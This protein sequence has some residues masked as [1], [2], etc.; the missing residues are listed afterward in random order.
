MCQPGCGRP[1]AVCRE[2]ATTHGPAI[3]CHRRRHEPAPFCD[4]RATNGARPLSR[5]RGARYSVVRLYKA[6]IRYDLSTQE[7]FDPNFLDEW[8]QIDVE[9]SRQDHCGR[10]PHVR[11]ACAP[12][13]RPDGP[14]A[15]PRIAARPPRPRSRAPAHNGPHIAGPV[16]AVRPPRT[17]DHPSPETRAGPGPCWMSDDERNGCSDENRSAFDRSRTPPTG[18][19]A[20][21]FVPDHFR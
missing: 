7:L 6:V 14:P 2:T 10:N 16:V 4:Q 1:L 20:V 9:R 21:R 3:H 12:C 17:R 13:R 15:V 18:Y 8:S 11:R 19:C 5:D